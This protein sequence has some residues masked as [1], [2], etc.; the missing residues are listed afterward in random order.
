MICSKTNLNLLASYLDEYGI[1]TTNEQRHTLL[2]HLD[3]VIE[4]N[5]VINLTRIVTPEDAIVRHVVDSLLILPSVKACERSS[6]QS[7]VDIGTG[8][9]FPGIPLGVVTNHHGLLIDS[10][11]KKV[12][13][14]NEFIDQLGL[15]E[16]LVGQSVRVED[17]ARSKKAS[18]DLVIARAVADLGVLV[19]YASPLLKQ[20]GHLVVSKALIGDDEIRRG[21]ETAQLTGMRLVSRETYELPKDS[22][23]REILTFIRK[24][25]SQVKLPRQTG[26][27][28][29]KPLVS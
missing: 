2:A 4:K 11:G 5:K 6:S 8:A 3:L 28:K 29:H 10:V 1:E 14:V 12:N 16:R 17:L 26:M 22:G 27:A 7:F 23:H 24:G 19:E 18:F 21:T 9:G 20:G 25:A 13:A 15:S